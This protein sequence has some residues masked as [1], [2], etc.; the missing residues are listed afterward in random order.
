MKITEIIF[1]KTATGKKPFIEWQTKLVP[2][3]ESVVL[4]R[5]ARMRGGNFGDFKPIKGCP[6]VYELR[7]DY[8]A[9]YRIYFGKSGTTMV[10]L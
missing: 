5:L 6:G 3:T 4:T 9:G 2:K 7:I 1:Y 8:G 10:V